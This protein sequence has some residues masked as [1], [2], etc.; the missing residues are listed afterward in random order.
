MKG[1]TLEMIDNVRISFYES[2]EDDPSPLVTI[3]N[4]AVM[5]FALISQVGRFG[6]HRAGDKEAHL[7]GKLK[8]NRINFMEMIQTYGVPV[9]V[10]EHQAL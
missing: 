8:G 9:E 10:V 2:Y 6:I 5:P 1:Y 3:F 7:I 4:P